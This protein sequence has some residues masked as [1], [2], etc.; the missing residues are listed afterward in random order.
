MAT[1]LIVEDELNLSNLIRRNLEE[2]GHRVLQVFDGPGFERRF[3]N[4]TGLPLWA[5]E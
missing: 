1:I 5:I 3:D 4:E 2:E